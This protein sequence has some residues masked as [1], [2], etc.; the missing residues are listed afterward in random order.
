MVA[1]AEGAPDK[2]PNGPFRGPHGPSWGRPK[3][4]GGA[5]LAGRRGLGY[6]HLVVFRFV[7]F[8]HVL[9]AIYWVGA[10]L[11]EALVLGPATRSLDGR[12]W[13]S[14]LQEELRPRLVLSTRT[15]LLLLLATGLANLWLL[16]PPVASAAFWASGFGRALLAKLLAVAL[17]LALVAAHS[18]VQIPALRRLRLQAAGG[19]DPAE[20]SRAAAAYARGRQGAARMGRAIVALAVVAVFLGVWLATAGG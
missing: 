8:L 10:T 9:A 20:A 11:F 18:L 1:T 13:L 2:G 6:A 17:L 14:D 3:G 19:S 4:R 7:L 16:R 5:R 15:A 12:P